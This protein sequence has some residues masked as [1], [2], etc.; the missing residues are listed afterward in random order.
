MNQQDL[1]HWWDEAF[2]ETV[3][4]AAWRRVLEDLTA[5][6]A[7]WQPAPGRR[8]IWQIVNHMIHWREYFVHRNRGGAPMDEQTLE[9]HN[10]QEITDFSESAWVDT[11]KRFST[12]HALVAE[13]LADPNRPDPPKPQLHPRYVLFHDTYHMGQVMF[14]RALLGKP[15]LES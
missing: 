11:R 15:S 13:L 10:W 4:W 3:W 12:S 7:A 8:S 14:L 6:E 5:A 9:A 2:N 1:A